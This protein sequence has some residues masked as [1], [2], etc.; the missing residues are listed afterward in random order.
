MSLK[1]DF[2]SNWT[3][4]YEFFTPVETVIDVKFNVMYSIDLLQSILY[5]NC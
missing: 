4:L 3:T 1:L 2:S 5:Y